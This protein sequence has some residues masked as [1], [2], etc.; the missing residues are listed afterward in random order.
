ML[1]APS[2]DV[3]GPGLKSLTC[4]FGAW[5]A[6]MGLEESGITGLVVAAEAAGNAFVLV[7]GPG[8][9]GLLGVSHEADSA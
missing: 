3:E 1:A 5:A 7:E 8:M 4:A 2:A 9:T 6:A